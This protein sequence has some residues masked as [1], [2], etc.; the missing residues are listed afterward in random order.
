[1]E[2]SILKIVKDKDDYANVIEIKQNAKGE[3]QVSVTV[4]DDDLATAIK[5]ATDGF[6]KTNMELAKK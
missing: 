5:R 6:I 3:T 4:R 2:E 1:M